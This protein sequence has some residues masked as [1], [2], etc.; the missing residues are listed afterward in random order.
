M[1]VYKRVI[2]EVINIKDK[3]HKISDVEYNKKI[4]LFNILV[5]D[6][7]THSKQYDNENNKNKNVG[8]KHK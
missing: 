7:T 2:T 5:Y 3:E 1:L 8:F 6:H 4:W